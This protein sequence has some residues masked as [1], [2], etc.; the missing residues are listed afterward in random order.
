[1]KIGIVG[2]QGRVGSLLV[3][4]LLSGTH[5]NLELAGGTVLPE[6]LDAAKNEGFFVTDSAE[7]LFDR[8]DLIIDFTI[9]EATREHIQL[10]AQTGTKYIIATTGLT[11]DDE[12]TI[13]NAAQ[14]APIIYSANMSI[15]VTIL[16]AL[17]EKTAA[18]LGDDFDIEIVEA[19][20]KH[21]IDA[22]SGTA[23]ML[24]RTAANAR[25][26]SFDDHAVLSREGIT[27]ARKDNEIGFS[28]IRGA[29]VVGEHT[30]YF[31]G[32]GERLELKQQATNRALYAKGALTAAKWL[33]EKPSGL[34]S[35]RDV[36]GL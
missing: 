31:L 6:H 16:D 14:N 30:V 32:N 2:C 1:M 36:L 7:E 17:V 23:I 8:A 9:P 35:M 26:L 3:Q 28:T 22:P 24:G 33:A 18:A 27:G 12:R 15:A 13:T 34:Y 20:H 5:G 19:H 25:D 4:E 29:D 21:K 10:A 11:S